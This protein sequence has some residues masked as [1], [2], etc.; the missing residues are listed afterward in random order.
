MET[1]EQLKDE[2]V[3]A[4]CSGDWDTAT[5]RINDLKD[6]RYRS[7]DYRVIQKKEQ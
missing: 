6:K 3:E 2:A 4:I 1:K 5:M 7:P